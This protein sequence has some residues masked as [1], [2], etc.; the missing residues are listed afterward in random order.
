[1]IKIWIK[2]WFHNIFPICF[3]SLHYRTTCTLWSITSEWKKPHSRVSNPFN[4]VIDHSFPF[5]YAHGQGYGGDHAADRESSRATLRL[6]LEEGFVETLVATLSPLAL[7]SLCS[8]LRGVRRYE[9]DKLRQ[10]YALRRYFKAEC[11]CSLITILMTLREFRF[12]IFK[13]TLLWHKHK[14]HPHNILSHS[15]N[16]Y[17]WWWCNIYPSK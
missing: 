4:V 3:F 1:M 10:T 9:P 17:W 14:K 13:H 7:C 2:N 5:E 16:A 15:I 8:N 12:S 6:L 11:H